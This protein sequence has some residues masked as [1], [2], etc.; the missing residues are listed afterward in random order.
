MPEDI[1][2]DYQEYRAMMEELHMH[3]V[4]V[5]AAKY[6][7][8]YGVIHFMKHLVTYI[9]NP[10]QQMLLQRCIEFMNEEQNRDL[11]NTAAAKWIRL[12]MDLNDAEL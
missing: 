8:S 3:N 9:D 5:D 7:D 12:N 1:E 6:S 11:R 2:Y 4:Y 10:A